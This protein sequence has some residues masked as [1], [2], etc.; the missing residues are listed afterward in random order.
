M[1]EVYNVYDE[2]EYS[3]SNNIIDEKT[4]NYYKQILNDGS[5]SEEEILVSLMYTRSLQ[6]R[7]K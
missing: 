6:T 3:L 2:L 5:Y 7:H 4:Y 1:N